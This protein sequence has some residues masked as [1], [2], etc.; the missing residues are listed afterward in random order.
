MR[1]IVHRS[2]IQKLG[3]SKA[4]QQKMTRLLLVCLPYYSCDNMGKTKSQNGY[5]RVHLKL[6]NGGYSIKA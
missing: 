2:N 4:N 6:P 1:R 3:D 5:S